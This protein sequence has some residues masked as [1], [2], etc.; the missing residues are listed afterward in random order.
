M[1]P[2]V[3]H[4]QV[5]PT[6]NVSVVFPIS[7]SKAVSASLLAHFLQWPIQEYV[8]AVAQLTTLQIVTTIFASCVRMD[9]SLALALSHVWIGMKMEILPMLSWIYFHFGLPFVF[10]FWLFWLSWFGNFVCQKRISMTKWRRKLLIIGRN[11]KNNKMLEEDQ[12]LIPWTMFLTKQW[13]QD[14]L[15]ISIPCTILKLVLNLPKIM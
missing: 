10:W 9:V 1:K 13:R 3:W 11:K 8:S 2:L 15:T 4:A 7:S 5:P 6:T 12:E 14:G